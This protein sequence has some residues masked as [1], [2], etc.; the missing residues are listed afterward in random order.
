[1][2]KDIFA[3]SEKDDEYVPAYRPNITKLAEFVMQ[4][5]GESRNMA[6]FAKVCNMVSTSTFSRIVN[7]KITKPLSIELIDRIIENAED[8]ES[9]NREAFMRAN[10]LVL[11]SKLE[12]E[13]FSGRAEERKNLCEAVKR[14]IAE[15]LYSRGCMLRIY[16]YLPENELPKSSFYFPWINRGI[17]VT[18]QGYEPKFWNFIIH[19]TFSD[20]SEML[21]SEE[22]RTKSCVRE[23]T[24]IWYEIFLRDMW[25]PET[26]AD[27][28]HSFV[29]TE[30]FEYNTF[31]DMAARI[32][33]NSYI[34]AILINTKLRKV[35]AEEMIP[36][37]DGKKLPRIFDLKII[38]DF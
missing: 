26:L 10:G 18:V 22:M 28:K 29:F 37:H 25:E 15:E 21:W 27:I 32:K 36:R 1:M 11:R 31:C 13:S 12:K 9:L 19:H 33:V 38:A 30:E 34:S 20:S 7:R 4:A 16:P 2:S 3:D 5:K 35:I 17:A 23:I 14:T 8:P 6:E 24:G